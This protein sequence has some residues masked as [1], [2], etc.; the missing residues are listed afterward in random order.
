MADM[1]QSPVY[2]HYGFTT[3]DKSLFC[4]IR[5]QLW[6]PKPEYGTGL[7]ASRVGDEFGWKAF[8]DD[9]GFIK[10]DEDNAFRFKLAPEARVLYLSHSDQLADLPRIQSLSEQLAD[11][12]G[13]PSLFD[14]AGVPNAFPDWVLLDYEKLAA[15][16]VDA[17]EV[18]D[19]YA[20]KNTLAL[21]DCNSICVM[22]PDVVVGV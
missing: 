10:C 4:L 13:I 18:T 2:I 1:N 17:I 3:F 9:G 6:R 22:N 11:H 16:G 8:C 20:L 5:N 21:W 15:D 19:Y 14:L 7:W 12:S